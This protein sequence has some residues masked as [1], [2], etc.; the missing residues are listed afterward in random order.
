VHAL[1][2]RVGVEREFAITGGIAKNSG[3]VRRLEK[4]LGLRALSTTF[5]PQIAGALGAALLARALAEKAV[6]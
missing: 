6:P 4:E 5:D 3:V 2:E 1:L